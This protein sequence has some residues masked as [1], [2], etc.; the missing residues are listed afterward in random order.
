MAVIK[1]IL[2]QIDG[3][4]SSAGRI[5]AAI[6]LAARF[7]AHVTGLVLALEPMAPIAVPGL[8]PVVLPDFVY[9][10]TAKAAVAVA[11]AFRDTMEKAGL[12]PDCRT[13]TVLSM[14]AA[15]TVALHG[16]HS[17]IVILGQTSPDEI[18]PGGPSFCSDVI[19]SA[20][21]P[22]LVVPYSGVRATPGERILVAW[23]ASRES[24]RAVNDALPFLVKAKAVTVLT[25]NP[26]KDG[27]ESRREPGAD[28]ALHLARHGVKVEAERAIAHD[29]SVGDAILAEIGDNGQDMVVMGAYGHS[30]LQEFVLGG[31]T[32]EMLN[33]MAA[34]VLM[35]H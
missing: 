13:V 6:G 7:D 4:K 33:V 1:D 10:E 32:R 23:N 24:A 11:A 16:R 9:E 8:V 31:V 29:I 15:E 22:A 2:V 12:T 17:D 18:I 19:M 3:G 14:D 34:P 21:R 26:D 30:R 20:G 35:S 27:M 28:I 5:D 25:V